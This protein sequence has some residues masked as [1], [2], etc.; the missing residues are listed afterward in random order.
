MILTAK[1]SV[2]TARIACVLRLSGNGANSLTSP[3][4]EEITAPLEM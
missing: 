1:T 2:H 3:H 4:S